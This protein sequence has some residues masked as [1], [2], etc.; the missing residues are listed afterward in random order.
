M[1]RASL[2]GHD[3]S[4]PDNFKFPYMFCYC[5]LNIVYMSVYNRDDEKDDDKDNKKDVRI[6][7]D[8]LLLFPFSSYSLPTCPSDQSIAKPPDQ[9]VTESGEESWHCRMVITKCACVT[10]MSSFVCLLILFCNL[11]VCV[12]L[13]LF[14]HLLI[15]AIVLPSL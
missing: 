1:L 3:W 6:G 4:C 15:I 11:L 9:T 2:S 12:W 5:M 7:E 14:T 13:A 10:Q 8:T